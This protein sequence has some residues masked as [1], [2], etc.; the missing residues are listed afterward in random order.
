LLA[1]SVA[2][3][4][5]VE[6]D[7]ATLRQQLLDGDRRVADFEQLK[8]ESLQAAQAAVLATAQQLSSKLLEDHKRENAEAKHDGEERVRQASELLAKQV[9][10]IAK[11]VQQLHGQM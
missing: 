4:F 7:L 5:A 11:A 2:A 6:R 10:E 3:R 9:D 1:R 8:R